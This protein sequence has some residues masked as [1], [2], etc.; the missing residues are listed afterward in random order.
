M[1]SNFFLVEILYK[2]Q[3]FASLIFP[4]SGIR[5]TS[6]ALARR[7]S[8]TYALGCVVWGPCRSHHRE[9]HR[10]P[11]HSLAHETM[12][13]HTFGKTPGCSLTPTTP[14]KFPES[15]RVKVR[16][17]QQ[18]GFLHQESPDQTARPDKGTP[19]GRRGTVVASR[20]G[21]TSTLWSHIPKISKLANNKTPD[22]TLGV[23]IQLCQ[24]HDADLKEACAIT[25]LVLHNPVGSRKTGP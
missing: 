7:H 1:D 16:G 17:T 25:F 10:H 4:W 15:V 3:H 14:T 11:P 5:V 13:A 19:Q 22:L 20:S 21:V 2:Q 23:K 24:Q 8:G 18:A 12:D 6:K 9:D